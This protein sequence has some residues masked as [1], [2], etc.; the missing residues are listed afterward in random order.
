MSFPCSF[1]IARRMGFAA[2]GLAF[3]FAPPPHLLAGEA[4][5]GGEAG[6]TQPA[7]AG[8][9]TAGKPEKGK[10]LFGQWSCGA[11]H[12]LADAGAAGQGGPSLDGDPNLS[13]VLVVDRITNGQNGMPAFGGQLS[14][15]DIVDIAA[16]VV[17]MAAK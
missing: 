7:A 4:A 3:A 6:L 12:V 16:Y 17:R 14:E 9:A 1:G 2:L 15:E 11:C 10:E 5:G 13:A 8:G